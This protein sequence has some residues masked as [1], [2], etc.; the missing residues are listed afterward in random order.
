[1][2]VFG[3]HRSIPEIVSAFMEF[4]VHESCGE[5]TPCRVGT[6]LLKER[7]DRILAGRGEPKDIDDLV[8]LGETIKQTSRCGLG[9]ASPNPVLMTIKGFRHVYEELVG[10]DP[11]GYQ[12]SFDL[13]ES[14]KEAERIA[15]HK[16]IHHRE[17]RT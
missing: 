4:F 13:A 17:V 12:R 5:C 15:G 16:S 2:I 7:I 6:V 3:P 14:V 10:T 11:N 1:M 9:Q 8:E